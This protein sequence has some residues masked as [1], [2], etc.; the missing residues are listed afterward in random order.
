MCACGTS[1]E[2]PLQ[3][4]APTHTVAVLEEPDCEDIQLSQGEPAPSQAP[5]SSSPQFEEI[6]DDTLLQQVLQVDPD[7]W[8]YPWE[9]M[10]LGTR[11]RHAAF[12]RLAERQG[13]ELTQV[14][15]HDDLAWRGLI[16]E[17]TRTHLADPER[18]LNTWHQHRDV[19]LDAIRSGHQEE[20]VLE[21]VDRALPVF[22]TPPSPELIATHE[23]FLHI[24]AQL[25]ARPS[26]DPCRSVLQEQH[27]EQQR[28]LVP[29]TNRPIVA[30]WMLRRRD[31]GGPELVAAW[32][33]ILEDIATH[34]RAGLRD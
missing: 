14:S 22:T 17:A 2:L 24:E 19:V 28:R 8:E 15:D 12:E 23:A 13:H 11:A 5:H 20:Q 32:T 26:P 31:E 21:A 4:A 30:G 18:L 1:P 9:L 7:S 33:T 16:V 6:L 3:S 27:R 25:V 34:L 10:T 29:L